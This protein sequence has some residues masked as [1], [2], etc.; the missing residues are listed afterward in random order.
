MIAFDT[1]K[2]ANFLNNDEKEY[3]RFLRTQKLIRNVDEIHLIDSA[4]NL[5]TSTL[6]DYK[7]FVQPSDKAHG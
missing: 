6:N 3:F 4:G 5:I 7:S 1:N 2:S